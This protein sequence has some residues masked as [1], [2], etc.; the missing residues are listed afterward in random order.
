MNANL[1]PFA[2]TAGM[3][4]TCSQQSF[5]GGHHADRDGGGEAIFKNDLCFGSGV[6]TRVEDF[7]RADMWIFRVP[8]A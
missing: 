3:R 8:L 1:A 2:I 5:A 6:A 4:L 7:K